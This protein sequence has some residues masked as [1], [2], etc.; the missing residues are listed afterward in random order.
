MTFDKA[1]EAVEA[2]VIDEI[3]FSFTVIRRC[4]ESE[5]KAIIEELRETYAPTVYMTEL[6]K[7]LLK[8]GRLIYFGN[9]Q[10]FLNELRADNSNPL[11]ELSNDDL[12]RAWLH[13][14]TIKVVD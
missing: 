13:P 3:K 5:I 10:V 7:D 6:Q 14:E 4:D 1:L 11:G 2:K 12:V 8:I 9:I